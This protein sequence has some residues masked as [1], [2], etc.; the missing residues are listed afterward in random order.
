M[1]FGFYMATPYWRCSLFL[2][3]FNQ[4][5][6]AKKEFLLKK[7]RSK[8]CYPKMARHYSHGVRFGSIE[9][10]V[11]PFSIGKWQDGNLY[12]PVRY[13]TLLFTIDP[14]DMGQ[15]ITGLAEGAVK[16][17]TFTS[18]FGSKLSDGINGS[19][20]AIHEFRVHRWC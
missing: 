12:D 10:M 14:E 11:R 9:S 5:L 19:E 15:R 8:I 6:T 17:C 7:A 20:A 1:E 13:K 16:A 4:F 3:K 18:F 2:K